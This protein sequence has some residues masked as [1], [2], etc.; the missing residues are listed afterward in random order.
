MNFPPPGYPQGSGPQDAGPPGYGPQVPGPQVPGPQGY[1]PP[2]WVPQDVP[3][4]YGPRG[5]SDDHTWALLSYLLALVASIIAPLV[6]YLVK[7]N[8]SRYVRFHAAQSLNLGI[9]ALIYSIALFILLI[10]IGIVTHGIGILL[11]FP[12]FFALGIAELVFLIMGAVR[13]S[14]GQ[15]YKIPTFICLPMVR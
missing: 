13:A 7:M 12:L 15:L 1:G 11:I 6:I 10:P 8:E 14:Q 2:G 3:Q 4:G 5:P 9:T